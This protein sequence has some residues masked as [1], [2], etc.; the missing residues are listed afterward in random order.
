M[1]DDLEL[2]LQ[3]EFAFMWQNNVDE[4]KHL[5]RRE[6]RCLKK[7]TTKFLIRTMNRGISIMNFVVFLD[8]DGV[9]NTRS[10]CQHTLE[11][12]QG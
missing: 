9:L 10:T 5:Y 3:E 7:S 1:R 6:G 12:I 4:E 11:V 2:K 8:V